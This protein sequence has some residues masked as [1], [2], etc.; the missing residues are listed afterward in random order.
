MTI[1]V[2][3][4]TGIL[5]GLSCRQC[6]NSNSNKLTA[7]AD[8]ATV[9]KYT[10]LESLLNRKPSLSRSLLKLRE[11]FKQCAFCSQP[12]GLGLRL[13]L[14]M[15]RTS[16]LFCKKPLRFILQFLW[17]NCVYYAWQTVINI[18]FYWIKLPFTL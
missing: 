1:T 18:K 3:H 9:V 16:W 8:D 5:N 10:C 7:G 15:R 11:Y 13:A 6:T 2:I 12:K 4:V 14:W 17:Q